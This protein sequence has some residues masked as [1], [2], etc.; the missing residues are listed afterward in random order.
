VTNSICRAPGCTNEVRQRHAR[1]RP[2]IYC[3]PACRPSSSATRRPARRLGV[4]IDYEPTEAPGRP[5][6]RVW[7]VRL[8]SDTRSV[9][10]ASGLGRPSAEHLASQLSD[11]I[12][13]RQPVKGGGVE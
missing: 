4:E 6:G 13:R 3:S 12:T 5:T 1:G 10:V 9:E 7:L 11:L 2:T 8:V